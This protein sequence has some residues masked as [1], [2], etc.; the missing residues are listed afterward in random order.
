M[1][2]AAL[3]NASL[4][5]LSD[6]TP[7][8]FASLAD[9][10]QSGT[11]APPYSIA[12]LRQI[13]PH[14]RALRVL[15]VL[16]GVCDKGVPPA[17][18]ALIARAI[19]TERERLHR[20]A[21][22]VALVWTGPESG[23]S[24]TRDTSVVVRELFGRAQR[25]VLVTG[26]VVHG[27]KTVFGPLAARMH[28][29]PDLD[30]RIFL[31]ISRS[32]GDTRDAV[33]LMSEFARQFAK[34]HWPGERAPSLFCDPRGLKIEKKDRAVLHAKCVVV[35]DEAALVTSANLTGAAQ[36]RNVEAGVLLE[37]PQFAKRLRTHFDILVDHGDLQSVPWPTA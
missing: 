20:A 18:I 7:G 17:H 11:L 13:V 14:D 22:R 9:A 35:D 34:E 31:N 37:D 16:Q 29:F 5:S 19:A 32:D 24:E 28:A 23:A 36:Y 21:D 33:H 2:G 1:S 27:G 8:H 12:A 3:D 10:L 25:S 26:F 15:Q 30:V 4:A 6:L